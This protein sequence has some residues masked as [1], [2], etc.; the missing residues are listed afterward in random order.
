M[1]ET[2]LMRRAVKVTRK[3]IAE[4]QIAFG[5]VI[6]RGQAVVAATRKTVWAATLAEMGKSHLRVEGG[7]LN[8]DGAGL[9]EEWKLAGGNAY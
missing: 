6:E 4:G 8:G 2:D 5:S 7:L 9:F 3:G 1:T